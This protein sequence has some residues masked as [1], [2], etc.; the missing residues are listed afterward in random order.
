MTATLRWTRWAA[1]SSS[2]GRRLVTSSS[3][4]ST[5]TAKCRKPSPGSVA[6]PSAAVTRHRVLPIVET[7]SLST[8]ANRSRPPACRST[9]WP[10]SPM[11]SIRTHPPSA[12]LACFPLLVAISLSL[13]Y[14]DPVVP[15]CCLVVSLCLHSSPSLLQ[16]PSR[17]LA[18]RS[19]WNSRDVGL[20][21]EQRHRCT[22]STTGRRA[23]RRRRRSRP[24]VPA[25]A[26]MQSSP[27]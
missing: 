20:R 12:K 26:P 13:S 7:P 21:R 3:T 15:L 23:P 19:S 27:L 25:S 6:R 5:V 16:F 2:E 10:L 9:L 24:E 14:E 8:H 17:Y 11:L 22:T 4:V 1:P 18:H